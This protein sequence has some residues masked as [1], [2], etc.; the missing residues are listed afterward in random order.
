MPFAAYGSLPFAEQAEFFRRKLNLPTDGWTDI[1]TSEHDWAFVVA[2]ANRDAIVADFR[3]AVEKAIAGQSTLE[4]FRK[5]FDRIVAQHGWDYNGGR[6]WRSRVIYDT[7]LATSYAAGRWQQL[8][9]A[10]FWQ[11]EHQDWVQHPRELHVKWDG[12]VLERDNQWWQTHFPPN[13]WG[14]QCKVRGLWPHDLQK[15]GKSGPDEAPTVNFLEREIG[16]RSIN[17]PRIVRVPEGID[18]GFEY[19][20]GS[21]RLRGAIPPE[22][23]T[24][25]GGGPGS[26]VSLGLPNLRPADP[27][28]A[29]RA[30]PASAVLP[31]GMSAEAYVG[32]FLGSFGATL[33]EPAVVRDVIGE[34]L[35]V[36]KELFQDAQGEWK[37][38]KR[39]RERYLPL[40][41]QALQAPDEIWARVEWLHA[42]GRAAVRRRY[43]A[44]FSVDGQETPGLVVFELG[45][46]GWAGITAFPPAP[47]AYVEDLRVGVRLYRREE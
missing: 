28:P 10:P 25:I 6:N 23:P 9:A 38:F 36:G 11:Y 46:D 13:G 35:V 1:Y 37:V 26:A 18:P 17:G 7:N 42:A 15:L 41:A 20:P 39:G 24:P 29:P 34:R 40:L 27:L 33:S 44:R 22:R 3:A 30:L 2:G 19:A 21:A 12:L 14:C 5:D 43:V 4:D 31:S 8:Q 32:E 16:Q 45:A 47:G